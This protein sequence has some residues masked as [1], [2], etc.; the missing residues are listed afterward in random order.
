[1]LVVK[2]PVLLFTKLV[3]IQKQGKNM[4]LLRLRL[5]MTGGGF[6]NG[7]LGGFQTRPYIKN[8]DYLV[9]LVY[10]NSLKAMI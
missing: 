4:R 7:N 1:M 9:E 5:A 8:P 2:T 10:S 6:R 3:H